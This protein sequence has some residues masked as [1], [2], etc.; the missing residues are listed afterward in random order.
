MSAS[1]FC[2]PA[3]VVFR[4]GLACFP[5]SFFS[6]FLFACCFLLLFFFVGVHFCVPELSLEKNKSRFCLASKLL[7][8][9][10]SAYCDRSLRCSLYILIL[11]L[12]GD[13]SWSLFLF[14]SLSVYRILSSIVPGFKFARFTTSYTCSLAFVLFSKEKSLLVGMNDC[15]NHLFK[16]YSLVQ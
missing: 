16:K 14:L 15:A 11:M 8:L 3:C 1:D 10:L 7:L 5:L 13:F 4:P 2:M 9:L 6:F 12:F